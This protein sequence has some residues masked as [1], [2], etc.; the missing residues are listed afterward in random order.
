MHLQQDGL[1]T[2]PAILLI[3]VH[4]PLLATFTPLPRPPGT[5]LALSS[6]LT[7]SKPAS[8]HGNSHATSCASPHPDPLLETLPPLVV[9]VI[10]VSLANL[11]NN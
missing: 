11:P 9:P 5:A 6:H 7:P 8:D 10:H 1:T 2:L 4:D 3:T